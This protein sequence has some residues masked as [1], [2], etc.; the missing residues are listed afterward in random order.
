MLPTKALS[1]QNAGAKPGTSSPGLTANRVDITAKYLDINAPIRAGTAR[2]IDVTIKDVKLYRADYKPVNGQNPAQ[3]NFYDCVA[4][5]SCRAANGLYAEA[6]GLYKVPVSSLVYGPNSPQLTVMYD[7][8]S[9]RLTTAGIGSASAGAVSLVGHILNSNASGS[10]KIELATGTL[11]VNL[12][13]QSGHEIDLPRIETGASGKGVIRITDLADTASV[14]NPQAK[15]NVLAPLTTWYVSADG[16][17]VEMYQDRLATDY[18]GLTAITSGSNGATLSQYAPAAGWRYQ[19]TRSATAT[20]QLK[21]PAGGGAWWDWY[22]T[23]WEFPNGAAGA[24][25]ALQSTGVVYDPGSAGVNY[26]YAL[27][28]TAGFNGVNVGYTYKGEASR[29][30][31]VATRATLSMTSS[32][33]ADF[34][35]GIGFAGYA[36][37]SVTIGSNA[38]AYLGKSIS[39]STGDT[40]ITLSK[41]ASLLA[42]DGGLLKTRNLTLDVAGSIGG[43][44]ASR[45]VDVQL[46]GTLSARAGGDLAVNALGNLVLQQAEAGKTGSLNLHAVGDISAADNSVQLRGYGIE[47]HSASGRIGGATATDP[48]KLRFNNIGNGALQRGVLTAEANGDVNLALSGGDVRVNSVKAADGNVKIAT[49]GSLFDYKEGAGAIARSSEELL[50]LWENKLRISGDRAAAVQDM[51]VHTIA[52]LDQ[53][54][55]RDYRA[56]WDLRALGSL[57]GSGKLLLS[58]QGLGTLRAQTAAALKKPNPSDAEVNAWANTLLARYTATFDTLLGKNAWQG[59]PEFQA[60]NAAYRFSAD[61]YNEYWQ[62][63]QATDAAR[64]LTAAGKEAVRA[65]AAT[66]LGGTPSDAQLQ[67]YVDQRFGALGRDF[68]AVLGGSWAS[69]AAFKSY[70]AGYQFAGD[71]A[72]LA[73]YAT[74]NYWGQ[75][76]LE[77]SV[78]LAALGSPGGGGTGAVD[79]LNIAG[80]KV[81][82]T[83]SDGKATLGRDNGYRL[84]NLS[85]ALSDDDR[86]ALSLATAPGDVQTLTDAQGRIIGLK[87]RDNRPVFVGASQQL[88]ADVKGQLFVQAQGAL[89][90]GQIRSDGRVRLLTQDGITL[91]AGGSAPQITAGALVLDGGQGS[92]GTAAAPLTIKTGELSLAK[93]GE[94][95]YLNQVEGSL[96]LDLVS[97]GKDVEINVAKGSLLQKQPDLLS[98]AGQNIRLTAAGDIGADPAQGGHALHLETRGGALNLDA[99]NAWLSASGTQ[100]NLG[101]SVL[102]GVLNLGALGSTGVLMSGDVKV[103]GAAELLVGGAFTSADGKSLTVRKDLALTA[104]S[105]A[106]GQGSSLTSSEGR[107]DLFSAGGDAL[108]G[109][110]S[111]KTGMALDAEQGQVLANADGVRFTVA[112]TGGLLSLNGANSAGLGLGTAQRALLLAADRVAL[113]SGAGDINAELLNAQVELQ[114]ARAEQGALSLKA[115]GALTMSADVQAATTARIEAAG[116]FAQAGGTLLRAGDSLALD[117]KRITMG[118]GSR[119]ESD[120]AGIALQALDGDAHLATLRAVSGI[121]VDAAK[122][123]ILKVA[124]GDVLEASG[125]DAQVALNLRTSGGLGVGTAAEPLVVKAARVGAASAQGG[126]YLQLPNAQSRVDQA[127]GGTGDIVLQA[128]GDLQLTGPVASDGAVTVL[129]VGALGALDRIEAQGAGHDLLL[130]AASLDLAGAMSA[131]GDARLRSDSGDLRIRGS[132]ASLKSGGSTELVSARAMELNDVQAGL[133]ITIDAGGPVN[134]QRVVAGRALTVL[135]A[136]E[137]NLGELRSGSD[138]SL[139]LG[140]ADIRVLGV[141][142]GL[143]LR[144]GQASLGRISVGGNASLIVQGGLDIGA[145]S[146]GGSLS[147]SAGSIGIGGLG[148]GGSASL[149]AGSVSI[150]SLDAGSIDIG[151]GSLSAGSLSA[152]GGL[153]ISAGDADLGSVGA[154]GPASLQVDDALALSQGRF[155]SRLDLRAGSATLGD[156]EV[157]GAAELAVE[158]SLGIDSLWGKQALTLRADRID[159]KLLR[160]GGALGLTAR[161][162]SVAELR[163]DADAT[164]AVATALSLGRAEVGGKLDLQAEDLAAEALKVGGTLDLEAGEAR[165]GDL[166]VGGVAT[167]RASRALSQ[168]G[169]G[170][171]GASL[172]AEAPLLSLGSLEIAGPVQLRADDALQARSLLIGGTLDLQAHDAKLGELAVKGAADLRVAGL[173]EIGQG[174]FDDVLDIDSGSL[175]FG[176]VRA[177]GRAVLKVAD[178]ARLGR[179]EAQS[180][181]DLTARELQAE[182]LKVGA[183]LT[184]QARNASLAQGDWQGTADLRVA[185]ALSL[186]KLIAQQAVTL[187]S[188][189][190]SGGDW[191]L[192]GTLGVKAHEAALAG[193]LNVTGA[194]GLEVEA[195]LRIDRAQFGSGLQASATTMQLGQVEVGGDAG[196]KAGERLQAQRL[197]VGGRLDAQAPQLL[198]GMPAQVQPAA[199][200]EPAAALI[201]KGALALQAEDLSVG[202][203]QVGGPTQLQATRALAMKGSSQFA[204]GLQAEAEVMDLEALAVSGGAAVLNSKTAMKVGQFGWDGTATLQ[205]RTLELG[206]LDG[207]GAL[208]LSGDA[209]KLAGLKSSAGDIRLTLADTAELGQLAL[210]GKAIVQV[211]K[212]LALESLSAG[213]DVDLQADQLALGQVSAGGRLALRAA[214]DLVGEALKAGQDAQLQAGGAITAKLV[215]APTL[216]LTAQGD[217]QLDLLNATQAEISTPTQIALREGHVADSVVLKADRIQAGLVG[218][219]GDLRTTVSGQGEAAA[220][221][222]ALDVDMPGHWILPSFKAVNAQLGGSGRWVQFDQAS[223]SG[224]MS[225]RTPDGLIVMD[226]D[227]ITPV[228]EADVQLYAPTD[229][230]VLLRD[231]QYVYTTALAL[232]YK[233]GQFVSAPNTLLSPLISAQSNLSFGATPG[234]VSPALSLRRLAGLELPGG[235]PEELLRQ[236]PTASGQDEELVGTLEF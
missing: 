129:A 65:I 30:W 196:L 108:L 99:Q 197:A 170:K 47:L 168:T 40:A 155:G 175:G 105:V 235:D 125:A 219:N 32:V 229:S 119:M 103:G 8:A 189:S 114:G 86:Y 124:A 152:G 126:I 204:G 228:P 60:R 222:V 218:G 100:L 45:A 39:N 73:T 151:A 70:D 185:E 123:Q 202:N 82:I 190:L 188:H 90:L 9:G 55:N 169:T 58:A 23:D 25:W 207:K 210:A 133:D 35:I 102:D 118:S 191:T 200:P 231:R 3:Y 203:A 93:A 146:V 116:D 109:S 17:N 163:A 165:L 112:D 187:Q 179:F 135:R 50:A 225:L 161:A 29:L 195:A 149:G 208:A 215:D 84:L 26:K 157:G 172:R 20:R 162:A 27:N 181:L 66:V 89:V 227:K 22:A 220:S 62:L 13:N 234:L 148:V 101:A 111:A 104:Q 233:P 183:A 160:A 67:A 64:K 136:P 120:R 79:H 127:L 15:K 150:G 167:L 217:I 80:R 147:A 138:M 115:Q 36:D 78:R 46:G 98:L 85:Q 184:L 28:A 166:S 81:E 56:Y 4:N 83:S 41:G 95:I 164:L 68:A 193:T 221:N 18:T 1:G 91:A 43:D 139:S 6:N 154:G 54:V 117:A 236:N 144:A 92:L 44:G 212:R 59:R 143:Q 173:L 107:L 145:G 186:D 214:Q 33:K 11:K 171:L 21:A 176:D 19:W 206:Q 177:S 63:V 51:L 72:L 96:T 71:A 205:A 159:A 134:G 5:P 106:M 113:R 53:Q 153:S 223:L 137:F 94:G 226:N 122:G 14:Y 121:A 34:G 131:G 230:F 192:A 31:M 224:I 158:R 38:N 182:A 12:Q 232:I 69:Q 213:T 48:L 42:H 132:G 52:P 216:S 156:V 88:D 87:V 75:D 211:G 180:T 130:R 2:D 24:P 199:D 97:A 10:S 141:G 57:D 110:L 76:K 16:K 128:D 7:A 37:G 61:R 174:R 77:N 194:A 74:G 209:L 142:G 49:D 201:V 198:L 140:E 178:S